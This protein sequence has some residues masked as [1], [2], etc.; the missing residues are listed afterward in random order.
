MS[1]NHTNEPS[2]GCARNPRTGRKIG[3][4]KNRHW[5]QRSITVRGPIFLPSD[6]FAWMLNPNT[7]YPHGCPVNST[8]AIPRIHCHADPGLNSCLS[9]VVLPRHPWEHLDSSVPEIQG[10]REATNDPK[11]PH[12]PAASRDACTKHQTTCSSAPKKSS[13]DAKKK[14]VSSTKYAKIVKQK[15]STDFAD[16][17]RCGQ[18]RRLFNL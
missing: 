1:T 3:G 8:Q 15:S 7:N 10:H 4:Q 2:A 5:R 16:F 14:T 18:S 6:F 11:G 17:H 12:G 13:R 9:S